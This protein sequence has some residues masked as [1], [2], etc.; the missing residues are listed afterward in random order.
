MWLKWLDVVVGSGCGRRLT[1]VVAVGALLGDAASAEP[2][3]YLFSHFGYQTSSCGAVGEVRT[4]CDRKRLSVR[5]RENAN[6]FFAPIIIK[7]APGV[8]LD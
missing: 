8:L 7:L 5:I 3:R 6:V 1:D 2:Q 4:Y